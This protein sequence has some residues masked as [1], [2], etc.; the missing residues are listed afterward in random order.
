MLQSGSKTK[1]KKRNSDSYLQ[2]L[3][4]I[5]RRLR[6]AGIAGIRIATGW[7]VW[8]R[9]PAVHDFSLHSDQ[10]GSGAHPAS[11][12]MGTGGSLPWGK[13]AEA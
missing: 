12:P 13:A 6:I 9:F 10:T 11:Y 2:K 4:K 3:N 1:K 8:V 5:T 7:T